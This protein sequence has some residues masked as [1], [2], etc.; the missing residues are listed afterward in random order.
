[1]G[2]RTCV[3]ITSDLPLVGNAEAVVTRLR[4]TETECRNLAAYWRTVGSDKVDV[5]HWT[6]WEVLDECDRYIGPGSLSLDV[7]LRVIRIHAGG[8]WRGFLS[9]APLRIAHL[10]AFRSIAT[11]LGS[12]LMAITHDNTDVVHE[13]FWAGATLDECCAAL[14]ATLGPSQ[15]TV[16]AIDLSVASAT[17]HHVPDVWYLERVPK[18]GPSTG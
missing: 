8:R 5:S 13:T 4:Q 1:M 7:T 14:E 3:F 16:D 18:L 6:P 9:V 17:E 12:G 15:P 2:T 10:A 11:A